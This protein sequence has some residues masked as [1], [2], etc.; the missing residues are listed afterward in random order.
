MKRETL[1]NTS[2][3]PLPFLL[4]GETFPLLISK[5]WALAIFYNINGVIINFRSQEQSTNPRV[6]TTTL[7]SISVP[8][9]ASGEKKQFSF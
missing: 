4:L 6:L 2:P 3:F 9:G 7:M 1:W 5:L 8:I